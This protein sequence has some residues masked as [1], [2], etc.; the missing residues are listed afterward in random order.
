MFKRSLILFAVVLSFSGCWNKDFQ[1]P[2][3]IQVA[4]KPTEAIIGGNFQRVWAAT[5]AALAKLP[6]I[7]KDVDA[8]TARAYVVTDWNRGKSDVLFHGF[9]E[10]R[11]PY[12]IRYKLYVYLATGVGG[13][14]V[15]IKNIEQ[16]M[17]DSITAGVDFQ[18]G[19]YTWIKTESSGLK[20]NAILEQINKLVHDPQFKGDAQ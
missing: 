13:T 9:G 10:N 20:E 4:K 7:R 18:G 16:Y 12:V 15:T 14:R 3:R 17:D 8:S 6:M 1:E 19:V 5:Q 2:G 11:M